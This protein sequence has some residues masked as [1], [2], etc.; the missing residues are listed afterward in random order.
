[1]L[2]AIQPTAAP[3]PNF[4]KKW[5]IGSVDSLCMTSANSRSLQFPVSMEFRHAK[6]TSTH[7]V[8]AFVFAFGE[9]FLCSIMTKCAMR[10]TVRGTVLKA[11]PITSS[12]S[13]GEE[14]YYPCL[15]I[16]HYAGDL[17][18]PIRLHFGQHGT[19]LANVGHRN[20]HI[21]PRDGVNKR[22]GLRRPFAG[23]GRRR[24]RRG[25]TSRAIVAQAREGSR[26]RKITRGSL[27][28]TD[29]RVVLC[30]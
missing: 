22:V 12:K 9:V 8:T 19:V 15:K 27:R 16:V 13:F 4:T 6:S 1:M 26:H 23:A 11:R 2:S 3:I 18:N 30:D 29:N 14:I 17:D 5:N 7:D 21:L 24:H 20:F 25:Q 28:S 10:P